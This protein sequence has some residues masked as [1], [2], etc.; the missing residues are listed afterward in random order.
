MIESVAALLGTNVQFPLLHLQISFEVPCSVSSFKLSKFQRG[1]FYNYIINVGSNKA[2]VDL[3]LQFIKL[4]QSN[5]DA[6]F[7]M[8]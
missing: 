7:A 4:S 6:I 8:G 5:L 3:V 1:I 2:E